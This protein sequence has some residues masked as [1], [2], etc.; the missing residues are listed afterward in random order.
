M[1]ID[2]LCPFNWEMMTFMPVIGTWSHLPLSLRND[3][4]ISVAG[5]RLPL[6]LSSRYVLIYPSCWEIITF[7]PFTGK[8][9]LISYSMESVPICYCYW[10]MI[11]FS[12]IC[13]S[14]FWLQHLCVIYLSQHTKAQKHTSIVLQAR[15]WSSWNLLI[16]TC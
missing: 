3:H 12:F 8:W 1:W 5:A 4:I 9:S 15:F 14:L 13:L 16:R 6:S 11:A 2:H 10:D 7:I